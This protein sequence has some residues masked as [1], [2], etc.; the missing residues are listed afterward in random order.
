MKKI[1]VLL[2]LFSAITGSAQK[3]LKQD[4]G[5]NMAGIL[6]KNQETVAPAL[7]YRYSIDK[8][9]LR[10][11]L[12]LD[13]NLDSRNRKG[14]FNNGGS[15]GNFSQDS[16]INFDP[17]RNVRYGFMLG[18][19]KNKEIENTD[20]SY[21]LGLDFLFMMRDFMQSGKG[22]ILQSNGGFDTTKQRIN[23]K[24]SEKNK[25]KTYGL[26]FPIGVTYK[27]GER[28]YTS[29]EAK[30]IIAYQKGNSTS[31][32]ET[33]QLINFQEFSTKTETSTD[34]KGFDFGIKPLTG[35]CIGMF[36]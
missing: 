24:V 17:G 10:A 15:F 19:Q 23:I 25:L 22:V 9:Q 18:I 5:L 35:L 20:F 1:T 34:N 31:L 11:Q 6:I 32:A 12:S 30:F 21:Y 16:A 13:G 14:H 29:L 3:E 26:A 33:S 8:Y 28:F 36:F 7:F 4:I 2:F 27:F